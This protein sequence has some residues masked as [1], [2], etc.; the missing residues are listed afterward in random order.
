MRFLL[1][2]LVFLVG[3]QGTVAQSNTSS[4][5]RFLDVPP[6]A[7]TAALGGNHAGLFNADFSLIHINPA[8][9][10]NDAS[11]SISASYLNFFSDANMGFT[12]GAYKFENIGTF[13]AGIRFVGYGEFDRLDEDGNDLGNFNANDIALTG[14]YSM[15]IAKNITAGA[16]I[17][18]IHSS[19]ASYKSSAVA[20]SGGFFY[21]DTASHFSAGISIRNLGGQLTAYA[22]DREPLPLDVSVG[23]TKKPEAFPFQLSLT[24]KKLNDWDL[25]VFGETGQ[26]SFVDNV[27]RHVI[28]GGETYFGENV[29]VRLG[30]DHYLHEQTQTGQDFDLAG[31]A[32]GVGIN[33]KSIVIDLS[34]NSYSRL[35]GVTRISLKTDLD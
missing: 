18:F 3:A 15:P 20:F 13:A 34:R 25:R 32:F 4:V 35:G 8:Y 17:D 28:F 6:T 5:F 21:Q 11:G 23:F 1:P 30:Y 29:T 10:N 16:G 7:R 31:I 14:A 27:F 24:F 19:Y 2:V 26:P 9:L 12:S 22:D 33:I